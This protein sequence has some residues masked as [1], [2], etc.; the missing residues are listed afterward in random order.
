MWSSESGIHASYY[1]IEYTL[2]QGQPRPE[3][4]VGNS[5]ILLFALLFLATNENLFCGG[6]FLLLLLLLLFCF[7]NFCLF[8]I[9]TGFLCVALAFL[10][11]SL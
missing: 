8:V 10:E 9:E 11:L 6:G 5:T 7:G 2:A 1:N 3:L 4:R